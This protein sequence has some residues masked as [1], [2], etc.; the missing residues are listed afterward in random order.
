VDIGAELFAMAAA[1]A[2]A[3]MLRKK[4]QSEAVQL[5][6]LFCVDARRR[7]RAIFRRVFDN[8]DAKSAMGRA[9]LE[10]THAWLEQG[11]LG[12]DVTVEDL[13]PQLPGAAPA[14][15]VA[16]G[17]AGARPVFSEPQPVS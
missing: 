11:G 17:E 2:R 1:C 5:A 6:D 8:D 15:P 13:R 10:G 3:E 16:V 7:V 4:G 12:L 9:V 14:R